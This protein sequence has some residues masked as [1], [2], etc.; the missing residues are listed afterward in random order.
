MTALHDDIAATASPARAGRLSAVAAQVTAFLE[1]AAALGL[2][3]DAMRPLLADLQ[4]ALR[5]DHPALRLNLVAHVEPFDG[6]L[7]HDVVVRDGS[8]TLAIGTTRG[9]GLPWPLRGV[10]K[11][12][13]Q[14]LLRVNGQELDVTR[15]LACLDAVFDDR[16]ALLTLIHSCLVAEVLDEEPIELTDGEVQAAADAFRRAKGLLTGQQTADWRR[17]R[18]MSEPE[19][20]SLVRRTATVA[21][22]RRRVAGPD[23][24]RAH[25][26]AHPE[27]Y[28]TVL[29][30]LGAGRAQHHGR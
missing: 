3:T 23:R 2:Q 12:G 18:A 26:A 24:V 21:A 16:S 14:Q 30:A 5:D 20:E 4:S 17:Q 6:S 19:F 15:A 10:T 29:L 25:F 22:L 13:E 11:A 7:A 1:D 9:P 27:R 8:D 28:A